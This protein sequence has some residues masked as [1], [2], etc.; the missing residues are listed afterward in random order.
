MRQRSRRPDRKYAAI[1]NSAMRDPSISIAG[2]G[3]LALLMTYSDDWVF[4]V[5]KLQEICGVGRDKMRAMLSELEEAGYLV[6]EAVRGDGG[7]LSGSTWVILDEPIGGSFGGGSEGSQQDDV[8]MND[9]RPPKNPAVGDT[10]PLK[11]RPPVE[12]TAGKSVPIRKPTC[13]KTNP[14]NAPSGC[15]RG[16]YHFNDS[17]FAVDPPPP[18]SSGLASDEPRGTGQADD[19]DAF[20][21][22]YPNPV[23]REAAKRAFAQLVQSGE[24]K[25]SDLIDAAKTYARSR[26]VERG[27]GKKPANWLSSGAWREEW[28]AGR[29]AQDE[30]REVDYPALAERWRGPIKAGATYAASAVSQ[31]LAR[32]MLGE[33]MVTEADLRRCGVSF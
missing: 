18:G 23:E 20:W 27:Y 19:F 1:P 17:G 9:H 6:R 28:E 3:L 12:P 11:T 21:S 7:Q 22:A 30:S 25:A 32:F 16:V 33:G 10:A 24:V 26:H 4:L 13:K 5:P 31:R 8:P 2:R 29:A 14:K 15:E